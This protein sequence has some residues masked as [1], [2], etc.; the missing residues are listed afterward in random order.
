LQTYQREQKPIQDVYAQVTTLF[1]TAPDLLEDF[2][3]FLPES[4]ASTRPMGPRGSEDVAIL[5]AGTS[6]P[7]P[8]HSG[9]KMPPIG[10]FAPPAS[11]S[12][13][14]KKRQRNDKHA[15]LP[16]AGMTDAQASAART[17]T[18]AA[19]P[20]K[21]AKVAHK[22][23]TAADVTAL[24]PTLTPRMPEPLAPAPVSPVTQ[25][26]LSFFERVRKHLAN[27]LAMNEFL[28]LVNLYSQDLIDGRVLM[29]KASHFLGGNPDL[30]KFL[31]ETINADGQD[32][33][34]DN[35]PERPSGRVSLSNCRGYGPSYRLLPKR[36]R[37][38]CLFPISV[39]ALY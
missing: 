20:N 3:Q 13:E 32:V 15:A 16:A 34:V 29:H 11:A 21:R 7:Q 23:S 2:K 22:P 35:Q 10:S 24:E 28:R 25:D 14:S 36:V 9:A 17:L 12:K 30:L 26:H 8:G 1:H 4:A 38:C 6:T 5:R 19:V 39:P 33:A 18:G 31:Q 37:P 27:R